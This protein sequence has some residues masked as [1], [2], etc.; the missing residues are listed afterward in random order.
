M[1]DDAQVLI[2]ARKRYAVEQLIGGP[3]QVPV[4][5]ITPEVERAARQW[6]ACSQ[7]IHRRPWRSVALWRMCLQAIFDSDGYVTGDPAVLLPRDRAG[8]MA[9]AKRT[10]DVDRGRAAFLFRQ[11]AGAR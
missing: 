11:R 8:F 4:T 2:A 1:T 9:L 7:L 3:A 10:P 6:H 5:V